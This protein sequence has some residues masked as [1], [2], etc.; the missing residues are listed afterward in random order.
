MGRPRSVVLC[1]ALVG[2][3]VG[4]PPVAAQAGRLVGAGTTTVNT[5]VQ[6]WRTAVPSVTYAGIGAAAGLTEFDAGRADFALSEF[7]A[8]EAG[9]STTRPRRYVPIAAQGISIVYNVTVD[10]YRVQGLRLPSAT[11]ADIFTGVVTRWDDPA[12]AAL[13]QDIPLPP[14]PIRPVVRAEAAPVTAR[15]TE[16]LDATQP[17]RWNAFCPGCSTTS[18]YP[19][20]P[21]ITAIAGALGV[22]NHTRQTNGT[23]ALLERSYNQSIELPQVMPPDGRGAF[24][25]QTPDSVQVGLGQARQVADG[26]FDYRSIHANPVRGAYPLVM[27]VYLV[28]PTTVDSELRGFAEYALCE[29]QA[30]GL[31]LGMTPVPQA[32]VAASAVA[33]GATCGPDRPSQSLWTEVEAGELLMSV[34]A[35]GVALPAP[36]MAPD[37]SILTTSGRLRTITIT[38]TRAG[39]PGWSLSGQLTD[40]TGPSGTIARSNAAWTPMVLEQAPGQVI[41]PGAVTDLSTARLLAVATKGAGTARLTARLDLWAPTSTAAGD[42]T[43]LLTLTAI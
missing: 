19:S 31:V 39:N 36:V 17:E 34:E 37:G 6:Q 7:T 12:I 2:L 25:A 33:V 29:G 11:I 22:A 28:V 10:G 20:A 16:W 24:V 30:S 4:A 32:Q 40:F 38:D 8:A 14:L 43:A 5:L 41:T 15:F 3:L 1:L 35:G 13:N 9:V 23:I 27:Y 21:G 26:S 42:Y 18:T